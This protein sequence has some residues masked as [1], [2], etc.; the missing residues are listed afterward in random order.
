M[1]NNIFKWPDYTGLTWLCHML[2]SIQVMLYMQKN[3]MFYFITDE[4]TDYKSSIPIK[5][6]T[7]KADGQ[8]KYHQTDY[9]Q[10]STTNKYYNR[11]V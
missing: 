11:L 5:Q 2:N 6:H 4:W 8:Q 10:L 9:Q 1:Q 7:N 3:L